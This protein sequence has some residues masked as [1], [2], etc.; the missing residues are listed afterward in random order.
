MFRYSSASKK[1]SYR[2]YIIRRWP[3]RILPVLRESIT[4]RMDIAALDDSHWRIILL[5]LVSRQS[6]INHEL[7]AANAGITMGELRERISHLRDRQLID[8]GSGQVAV[9]A[10]LKDPLSE[11]TKQK[12]YPL[13][14]GNLIAS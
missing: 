1:H 4:S 10:A 8:E 2:T 7:L 12:H 5:V 14:K 11:F 3:F 9:P 6:S 13:L